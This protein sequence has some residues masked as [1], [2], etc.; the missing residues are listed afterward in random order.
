MKNHISAVQKEVCELSYNSKKENAS[1]FNDVELDVRFTHSSGREWLVPAF[2]SG[3]K[4]WR[5]RFAP[6]LE[7]GYTAESICSVKT[8]SGLHNQKIS[9]DAEPYNGENPL[10]RHGPLRI[11]E[12]NR[13]F[14]HEDGT[15]FFWLGDTWWMGLCS[16][17]SWPDDFKTLTSD[18]TAKGFTIIQIVA[19]LYPDMPEFD[20]RG[21]NEAGYPWEKEYACIN[22][23]YFNMADRRIS[24]LVR[25]GLVPCIVGSWGYYLPRLGQKKMKQHWRYLVARWGAYPVTWCLA[26]EAGMPWYLSKNKESDIAAQ[27]SGWAETGRYL[28][29]IDSFRHPVTIHPSISGRDEV[30]DESVL[31]F[32]MLQ[33]GH[34]GYES[35]AN[36]VRYVVKERQ[37]EPVMPVVAAEVN[38]EGII[39]G[40]QAEIQRLTYWPALLSGAAGF[41]YGANGIWQV[42][43][44]DN[45]YGPSPH[46]AC[47]G[48][49]SWDEAYKLHGSAH[50]GIAGKLL[51][52]YQWHLFEP[53]P[54]WVEPCGSPEDVS[55]PFAAGIPEQVRIIYF[56]KPTFPWENN[57]I[58]IKNLEPDITYRAFFFCPR[59]GREY[60]LGKVN[61]KNSWKVPL[62]PE[63][64]DWVLVLE[65]IS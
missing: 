22:P 25:S 48:N 41:T 56:Y 6:P 34:G 16:R 27:V 13:G 62:Q 59:S 44:G 49:T 43:T 8:D 9:L 39:H 19:G 1:P 36:T 5:V 33:T 54:E 35:S 29:K 17:F 2:W 42:N 14:E 37:R 46:G 10:L 7:G 64:A 28:R 61:N 31:D 4:E 52:K 38:Y 11:T 18:R 12:S 3:D 40:T 23:A 45:P 60:D 53:H 63:L 26:G 30:S 47:W 51:R 21:V 32:N 15:P 58:L 24:H 65:S 20:G 50:L 55:S 57:Y